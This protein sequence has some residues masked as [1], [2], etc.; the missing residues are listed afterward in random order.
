VS[1][2]RVG[3]LDEHEEES[4]RD[5]TDRDSRRHRRRRRSLPPAATSSQTVDTTAARRGPA[6][7]ANSGRVS[8]RRTRW[9]SASANP[10]RT[11]AAS[12]RGRARRLR[13]LSRAPGVA[14][15]AVR[16]RPGAS[17]SAM[18]ASGLSRTIDPWPSRPPS[19]VVSTRPESSPKPSVG[20]IRLKLPPAFPP[21]QPS[22]APLLEKASA[23]K[24]LGLQ[25]AAR[26]NG[27]AQLLWSRTDQPSERD[28][29]RRRSP[30]RSR[31]R[32][33]NSSSRRTRHGSVA[34]ASGPS[35]PTNSRPGPESVRPAAECRVP[36]AFTPGVAGCRAAVVDRHLSR[37]GKPAV[38]RCPLGNTSC[39]LQGGAP[40]RPRHPSFEPGYGEVANGTVRLHLPRRGG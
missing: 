17:R 27:T 14:R 12:G 8:T 23:R 5:R 10:S 18:R 1:D 24:D 6:R 34:N 30:P 7:S 29:G 36:T 21:S 3:H 33:R 4:I 13:R 11:Q 26:R 20:R 9:E 37:L 22:G 40:R 16:S 25:G 15:P 38:K 31:A 35:P 19:C 39:I 28:V 32:T 2:D